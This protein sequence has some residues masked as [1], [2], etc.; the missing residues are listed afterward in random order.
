[1][2]AGRW[3]AAKLL[4]VA[5]LIL[6]GAGAFEISLLRGENI[7]V[8]I[9]P[10]PSTNCVLR[11]GG[12]QQLS[13]LKIDPGQR[14]N[15]TFDCRTPEK[16]WIL[17]IEKNI[18]CMLGPCPFGDVPLQPFGLP[19]LNR[20]FIWDVKA[21]KL[22]GLELKFSTWLRQILPGDT[23]SDQVHY[24]IGS[25]LDA[26]R[27]NIGNFCRNG[28][29]SRVKVQGGVTL[30][31][32]LPWNSKLDVSGFKLESRS[33]IQ[34]LCIIE[35]TFQSEVSTT[36]M[37]ANY[38]LG[39]P[40]D[41]L[42]TWQFVIP[43]NLRAHVF[44]RNYTK[45]NCERKYERLEY[46]L[47]GH[48]PKT[49]PLNAV[50]PVN[51]AGS[52]NLSL[53][54]CDQDDRKPGALSLLFNVEVRYPENEENVTHIVDLTKEKNM[55]LTI[56][57]KPTKPERLCLICIGRSNKCEPKV[58]LV[59]GVSYAI[60][61][62]CQNTE[63]IRIIAEQSG[64]CWNSRLCQMRPFSLV[65]PPSLTQ[66]PILLETFTW[67]LRAPAD[68]SIEIRSPTLKLK[69][70]IPNQN[71]ICS[72]SYNY[73]INGT[74]PEK[75]LSLGLFCPGGAI[76]KIQ[77]KD[78]VTI[79]LK[80]YGKRWF[81]ESPKQDLQYFFRPVIQEDCIFS[82]TPGPK[83]KFYLQTPNWLEGLPAFVSVYWN[84][85]VPA[86]QVAQLMF[87]KD[88][89][90]VTCEQG[91]ANIY[92]KEQRSDAEETVRRHDQI[93]PK[94]LNMQHHFWVNITNCKPSA[95]Q[96]LSV[97]FM[98][99]FHQK[100]T[101]LAV[102]IGVV[103]GGIAVLAA[104]G[105]VICCTKRKKKKENQMPMVGVYNTNV[106][107]QMPRKKGIFKKRRKTNVSHVYAVIDDTMVYGHLLDNSMKPE[108]AEIGVYQPFSG[109]MSTTPPSPP[110]FRKES[111]VSDMDA[112][113]MLMT[114]NE[115]YTF[116]H[117]TPEELQSNGDVN[118]SGNRNVGQSLPEKNEQEN[119]VE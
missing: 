7:T 114:D 17:V 110:P 90:G 101:G 97:Q 30:T 55:N 92:I 63:N 53:Q 82:L 48:E 56:Y 6:Q 44:F 83:A 72:G 22:V 8:R 9:K 73:A 26:N 33:S 85:T 41:E 4:L 18:D 5:A 57:S 12:K 68:T 16:Y 106:N 67:K 54:G 89:L 36:L 77:M 43:S 119:S 111:K 112:S 28:S 116:A 103:V 91:W 46:C 45:P 66:L 86:K 104:I 100:K 27:V 34:R 14:L 95:K 84:I 52:F 37:S 39:L 117:R 2:A 29:V 19:P 80:T 93:L 11:V 98:V 35:S 62:L 32:Q 59:S 69:Q 102:I 76:E 60:T 61:F 115:N 1:M 79:T 51:I 24:N 13:E 107:T 50:Q 105:L 71:Q 31:L 75:A 99:T 113:L 21:D 74:A 96:L 81:T 87:P 78:N 49:L 109:P 42:M 23:C 118:V 20:T 70:H 15:F 25:R 58:T 65:V 94:T 64:V 10:A 40:E 47:P 108:N 3:I 88:R 38:P